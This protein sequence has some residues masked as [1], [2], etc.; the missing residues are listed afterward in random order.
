MAASLSCTP[1]GHATPGGHITVATARRPS[2]SGAG[3]AP[4]AA[5]DKRFRPLS[6]WRGRDTADARHQGPPTAPHRGGRAGCRA[7]TSI[8]HDLWPNTH[9]NGAAMNTNTGT[10]HRLRSLPGP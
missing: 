3:D 2:L 7:D 4:A 6:A 5:R 10:T 1:L 9:K 8:G